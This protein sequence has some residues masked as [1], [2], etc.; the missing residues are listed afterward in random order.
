[1]IRVRTEFGEI[2]VKLGWLD[3]DRIHAAPEFDACRDKAVQ[4][5]V[6]VRQVIDA[7]LRAIPP[8]GS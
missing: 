5:G 8:T 1:M 6:P 3:G 7:A 4:A 2:P